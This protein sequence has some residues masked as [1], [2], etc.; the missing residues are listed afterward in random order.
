MELLKRSMV[1]A[2][3][4]TAGLGLAACQTSGRV[5]ASGDVRTPSGAGASGGVSGSAGGSV[6]T[7]N[8]NSSN[9]GTTR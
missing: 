9:T 8:S 1:L 5:G 3:V 2:V 6:D 7:P 4:L